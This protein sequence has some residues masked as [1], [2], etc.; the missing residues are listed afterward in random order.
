[1]TLD[2][3]SEL[4]GSYPWGET[5]PSQITENLPD[6]A[7]VVGAHLEFRDRGTPPHE[8]AERHDWAAAVG[9]D[10]PLADDTPPR[11]GTTSAARRTRR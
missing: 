1:M 5:T 10:L 4:L 3:H 2:A 7:E 11:P 6:S 8:N 9:S